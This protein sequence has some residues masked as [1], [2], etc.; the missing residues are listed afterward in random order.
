MA[1]AAQGFDLPDWLRIVAA[2]LAAGAGALMGVS[3]GKRGNLKKKTAAQVKK[4]NEL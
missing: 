1:M 2:C 4:E 3:I